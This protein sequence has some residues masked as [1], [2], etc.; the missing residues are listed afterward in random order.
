[1]FIRG[2][3]TRAEI[4]LSSLENFFFCKMDADSTVEPTWS[5]LVSPAPR[6]GLSRFEGIYN[7]LDQLENADPS[8]LITQLQHR[9]A[10]RQVDITMPRPAELYITHIKQVKDI[11]EAPWIYLCRHGETEPNNQRLLQGSG[12]D[13]SLNQRGLEQA[14]HL[15]K[16]LANQR[17]DLI[18]SSG[19]KRAVE[20]AN[21]IAQNYPNAKR[22]VLDGFRE[23]SWGIWEG[24]KNPDLS[25]LSGAW[26][27]GDF[28]AKAFEGESPA[29]C[30]R[31]VIPA[32]D[33]VLQLGCK[34]IAIVSHGRLL[35]ILMAYLFEGNL[36]NMSLYTHHNT[37]VN[38][39]QPIPVSDV[40]APVSVPESSSTHRRR[41]RTI[42]TRFPA[43]ELPIHHDNPLWLPLV[44]DDHSH[45]PE[46]L[47]NT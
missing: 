6:I 10:N 43:P 44:L 7:S 3:Q 40:K 29:D 28:E 33:Q 41:Y 27:D 34:R 31:R 23:I 8:T 12:L 36:D 20:T 22:L 30:V 2:R 21:L 11:S 1:M 38:V 17:F 32:L 9:Q 24:K 19:L 42:E 26:K 39:V 25:E 37:C 5:P 15:G 35:R 4:V 45:V 18:V 13:E 47:Q 16:R 14:Q 46:K